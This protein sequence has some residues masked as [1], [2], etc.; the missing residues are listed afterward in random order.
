MDAKTGIVKFAF[1]YNESLN[2]NDPLTISYNGKKSSA[3][4]TLPETTDNNLT[5]KLYSSDE[6]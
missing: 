6:Y 5:L 4:F 3:I 1:T 2:S